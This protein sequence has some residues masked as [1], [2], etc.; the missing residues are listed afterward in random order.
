MDMY[1]VTV[2]DMLGTDGGKV[3]REVAQRLGYTYYGESEL[4]AAAAEMGL[5]PETKNFDEKSPDFFSR[6]FS[7]KPKVSLDRLQAVIFDLA[8]KGDAVFHGRGSQVLLKSFECALHVLVTGSMKKRKERLMAESRFADDVAERVLTRSDGDKRGFLRYAFDED[9]LNPGLF[10][11]VLN[12]DKMS[13]E[14]AVKLI[15]EAARSDEI[16]ACGIDSAKALGKLA[17]TRLIESTL[18]EEG[19]MSSH[20]FFT[21]EDEETV[22]VFGLVASTEEREKVERVL[23]RLKNVKAVRSFRTNKHDLGVFTRP[24]E[25]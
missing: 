25:L 10:D 6:Y 16:K 13:V 17:L 23:E 1:F 14:S 4:A 5:P 22:Q 18:I 11:L 7:G 19:L 15:V 2:S 8:K 9:W 24:T 3:A 21:V 20:L 12:T